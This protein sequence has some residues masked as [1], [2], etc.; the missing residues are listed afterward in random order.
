M[1]TAVELLI[2][3][4]IGST[5]VKCGLYDL[6][7]GL[8]VLVTRST[9]TAYRSLG[10]LDPDG[11]WTITADACAAAVSS[12]VEGHAIVVR[13]IAVS[14][15]GCVPV[16]L[17][18]DDRPVNAAVSEAARLEAFEQL[19]ATVPPSDY[20]AITGYPLDLLSA[21]CRMAAVPARDKDRTHAVLSVAD[22]IAFRLTGRI[23][24]EFSTALSYGLWD[25]RHD[26]WWTDGLERIGL[27]SAV[28]GMPA[29]SG[30]PIGP[31]T[32]EAAAAIG[33]APSAMVF[34][35]GHDYLTA[36]LAADLH[37]GQEV[38]NVTGTIE[39]LASLHRDRAGA[40][41]DVR[42]RAIKDHHVVPGHY[43]YMIE[44]Y[45]AG[46][47]EWLRGSV[48]VRPGEPAP[49]LDPWFAALEH[50][51]PASTA[52]GA[53]YVPPHFGRLP[54]DGDPRAAGAFVGL[55]PEPGGATMLRA[56]V[57]GLCFQVRQMLDCQR[58][59]LGAGEIGITSVGGGSRSAA[60]S[61]TK[62][63]V[64]GRPIRVPRVI[65]ASAHGAALLAG[66]GA[67]VY[68][69]FDEAGATAAALGS[70]VID[71]EPSRSARYQDVYEGAYLPLVAE[72][73]AGGARPD[74]VLARDAARA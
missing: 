5:N 67:G 14:S 12:L 35:G 29:E 30:Q 25:Y 4:D 70:D 8:V 44:A 64:L 33:V 55:G 74:T 1:T 51:P 3:I 22:Y 46:L 73:E 63:D 43:S 20:R 49:D 18:A 11:L 23:V 6:S 41:G 58:Q 60:W 47:V 69:G 39:I 21:A 16:L 15:I 27:D 50:L 61:Q 32:R 24:R 62:A 45:G 34:T 48:L 53:L 26:A 57:E 37:P 52:T 71:P 2:G 72:L 17:D 66:I 19:A 56:M 40:P 38:L 7:A 31:L 13:G 68:R 59:V 28:L 10:Q 36:A 54:P 42:V 9:A 65:E